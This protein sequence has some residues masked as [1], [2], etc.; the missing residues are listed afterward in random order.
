MFG[1]IIV[2][3]LVSLFSFHH[4]AVLL[5]LQFLVTGIT[6]HL[7]VGLGVRMRLKVKFTLRLVVRIT[8]VYL[9]QCCHCLHSPCRNYCRKK[10]NC[11]QSDTRFTPTSK[12][13]IA[14]LLR[15]LDN[16]LYC[17]MLQKLHCFK[18]LHIYVSPTPPSIDPTPL[19]PHGVYH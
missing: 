13:I 17:F 1:D 18:T 4:D 2:L 15:K 11:T 9:V 6:L 19:H 7:R 16:A 12:I 3:L 14:L 8:A 5:S 10:K